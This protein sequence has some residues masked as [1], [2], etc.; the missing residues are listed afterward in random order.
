MSPEI[1]VFFKI[2]VVFL[3]KFPNCVLNLQLEKRL[4]EKF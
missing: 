2:G 3:V 4:I 1:L